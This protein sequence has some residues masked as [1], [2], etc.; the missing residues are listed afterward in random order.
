MKIITDLFK[1]S[2]CYIRIPSSLIP[3]IYIEREFWMNLNFQITKTHYYDDY[4]CN[5][6]NEEISLSFYHEQFFLNF[7]KKVTF[8]F[9]LEKLLKDLKKVQDYQE[10][11]ILKKKFNLIQKVKN[12]V[13]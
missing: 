9:Q 5:I 8:D 1:N 10:F 4:Y 2:I 13:I 6:N 7:A 12:G 3:T 11:I